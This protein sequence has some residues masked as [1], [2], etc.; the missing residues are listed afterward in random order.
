MTNTPY[1]Q[2]R[3]ER[4]RGPLS[5]D[6]NAQIEEQFRDLVYLYNIS[7]QQKDDAGKGF[8]VYLKEL[9]AAASALVSIESRL[10][11]LEAASNTVSFTSENQIDNTRFDATAYKINAVDQCTFSSMYNILTL[12][13]VT[14]SSMSKIKFT[15]D[16]G[17]YSIPSTLETYISGSASSADTSTA[18]IDTSQPY[19]AI[20]ASPGKVWERNVIASAPNVTYGAEM[21]FYIRIPNDLSTT[22]D[23][24]NISLTPFPMK[25]VDILEIAYSTDPNIALN[26]STATWTVFNSTQTY[27][28]APGAAG[29]IIPGGW[30][31]DAILASGARSFYFNPKPITA[32][33]F[34]LRQK[35]YYT[36]GS[37]TIYSY[38]LSKLDV[39]YDKF[40]DTGKTI[41][42][43]DAPAGDTISNIVSLTPQ[44]WNVPEYQ[45]SSVFSYRVIWETAYNSNVYTLNKVPSSQR[46][47]IEVTLNKTPE[48]GT[49]SL[50]GLI[51]K[52]T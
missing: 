7:A 20:V 44:I 41:I 42:R 49:P 6:F 48:G 16:D 21:Y 9:T 25:T 14:S 30:S 15:N 50:S 8:L 52:Y 26:S 2:K 51:L 40:L 13:K 38:G 46:I 32:L 12:P 24:N 28:N 3:N 17:T 11:A 19:N 4:F 23:T 31:G 35:N 5:E 39:R 29:N 47:W 10:T 18:V 22:A 36:E 27:Y 43:F 1:T 37:K 33:R 45:V 34:K